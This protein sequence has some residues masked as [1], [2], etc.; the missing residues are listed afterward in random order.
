MKNK[1]NA[2]RKEYEQ[3]VT[4]YLQLLTVDTEYHFDFWVSDIVGG[5]ACFSDSLY[6]SLEDI[7]YCVDHSISIAR[8]DD[9]Q[10]FVVAEHFRLPEEDQ[11]SDY[12][13]DKYLGKGNV[14]NFK[15]WIDEN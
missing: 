13:R 3:V 7:I 12:A 2:I 6:M 5:I 9:Y 14:M 15:E 10:T 11:Y 4:K 1:R 8:F